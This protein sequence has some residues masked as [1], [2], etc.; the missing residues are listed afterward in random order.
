MR[1]LS[2]LLTAIVLATVAWGQDNIE[3]VNIENRAVQDYMADALNTYTQNKDSRVSVITKYN[4]TNIYGT[5]LY[6]PAGKTVSW[7]PSTSAQN[8]REIRITA[9]ENS[10]YSNGYTF[11]PDDKSD[12]TFEEMLH[13]GTVSLK[14]SGVFRT[15]GQLRMIQV[16]NCANVR[17][18]GGWQTQYGVPVKYGRLYRSASLDRISSNGR[19]DF[20]HNLK[21]VAELDLRHE[22]KRTASALG[23]DK[24]YLRLDH[25]PFFKG[26]ASERSAQVAVTDLRWILSRLMEGKNVDWHCAIGCDRCGMVSCL[27]GGLLGMS[28]VDLSRDF[29]LSTLSLGSSNKRTRSGI[30]SVINYARSFGPSND[31]AQGFYNYWR[32][33]GMQKE[34]LD[35][36]IYLM[37]DIANIADITS[38]YSSNRTVHSPATAPQSSED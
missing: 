25:S 22:V 23:A 5:K 13:N 15:I 17:D 34:E 28:E 6:W 36:F 16:R 26:L 1:K 19:H 35:Y 21:V 8:I 3:V 27:V 12:T 30:R 14:A 2:F 11:N 20:V 38:N 32:S 24:D 7:H 33:I 4:N 31:L 29:E 9:S 10:D 37:L 18:M